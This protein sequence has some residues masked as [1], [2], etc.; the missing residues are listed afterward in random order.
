MVADAW[1]AEL[2]ILETADLLGYALTISENYNK[3]GKPKMIDRRLEK[4]CP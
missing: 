2:Y 3:T 1:L 4:C